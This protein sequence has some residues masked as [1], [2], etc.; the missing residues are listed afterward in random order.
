VVS[1]ILVVERAADDRAQKQQHPVY[2]VSE[3][4]GESIVRYYQIQKILY[5]VL[6]T[7]RKLKHYFQ[8]H[9]IEVL[10]SYG[11]GE[12]LHNREATSKISKWAVELGA[13]QITFKP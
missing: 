5:G 12:V 7:A 1:T 6:M 3:V 8:A 11:I 13:Y 2:I 10:S 9:P 4:L